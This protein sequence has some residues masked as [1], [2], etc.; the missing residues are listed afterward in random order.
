MLLK[1]I[2]LFSC[3]LSVLCDNLRGS[4]S[5]PPPSNII[6]GINWFGYETEYKD[7]MCTWV[8][9]IEWNLKKMKEI[10]FN[11]IRLPFSEEFVKEGNW[12][13]MDLFFEHA[14]KLKIDVVLDFHRLHSTHQS[15]KPYDNVYT[16][17][18]FLESWKIILDRYKKY[19]VLKAV[20]IF[21]EYQGSNYVEWNS[22]AR[23]IVS[24]IEKQ[25]PERFDYFVGGTNWGGNI[26]YMDLTDLPFHERIRYSVHK[27]WFSDTEPYEE[28]W[29]YSFGDHPPIVN[30]GE[31][32]FKSDEKREV[33]WAENFIEYLKENDLRDTFFWTWSWNSGDTGGIL[34]ETCSDVDTKKIYLLNRL[35]N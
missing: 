13:S 31:W 27:Y 14:E 8:N 21:N 26:H 33:E 17:D 28:K 3:F 24:F 22:L 4:I 11:Y 20:D 35:W 16:F 5:S 29:N 1:K 32:G 6:K 7:L 2:L 12:E 10:G 18:D 19:K 30:V 25:F 34:T 23:Q 9:D 15:F